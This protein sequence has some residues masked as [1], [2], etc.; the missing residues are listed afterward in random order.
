MNGEL[1]DALEQLEKEKGIPKETL[2]IAMEQ[3]LTS[4]YKKE[5]P[6]EQN[7]SVKIEREK[8]K[9]RVFISKTVVKSPSNPKRELAIEEAKILGFKGKVGEVF[10]VEIKPENLGRIAAQTAKQVMVQKIKEAE[11]EAIYLEFKDK[12]GEIVT[13]V[14]QGQQGEEILVDLGKV[15][16]VI[17]FAEQMR[18]EKYISQ[19]H[20]KLYI[21]N[22]KKI[23]KGPRI[24]VSRTHPGLVREL[25]RLEVP[26]VQDGIIKIVSVAREPGH[27]SKVAVMSSEENVEPIGTCVGQRGMRV[28]AIVDELR[29]EKMDIIRFHEDP[30]QFITNALSPAKVSEVRIDERG[31][32]C[33]AVIPNDQLSLAIGKGG[34]NVRLA[35][36]LTGWRINICSEKEEEE[37][38]KKLIN[39][40]TLRLS[41][42]LLNCF[43]AAKIKTVGELVEKEEKELSKL[44]GLGEKSLKEIKEKIE[45]L[46]LSF[47][48]PRGKSQKSKVHSP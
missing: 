13:G 27:R 17:P 41:I 36:K 6:P 14:V 16:G 1:I 28:Q 48:K 35:S 5:L 31:K 43:R 34:Q 11:R 26:E 3:A 37:K 20:L 30:A 12:E 44:K 15:D 46:G 9:V 8:G 23:A 42:R 47:K 10:E 21:F 32:S 40:E 19:E 33:S 39:I 29:G 38:K 4:A 25:F 24:A 22:V 18:G 7:V 2:F 45:R